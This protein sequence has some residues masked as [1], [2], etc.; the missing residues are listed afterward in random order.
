MSGGLVL[1]ALLTVGV[2]LLYRSAPQS[3]AEARSRTWVAVRPSAY[4]PRIAR[5]E[6]QVRTARAAA[7][8]GDTASAVR[9]YA[10]GAE[11]AWTARG[12]ASTDAERATATE[13]WATALLD[14]ADLMLRAASSPWWRRD[15]DAMLRDALASME[16]VRATPA[17]PAAHRR[18]DALARE[19]RRQ[20]QPGPLE[21]I[22]RR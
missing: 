3:V 15:D 9:G 19:I 4:A 5:A 22:P 14:R 6:G 20:L 17:S 10:A 1:L 16:R 18:A 13:L 7:E 11:E 2:V 12:L 21:W 8:T